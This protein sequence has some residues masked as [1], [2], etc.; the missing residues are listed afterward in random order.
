M[1][2]NI[3]NAW[4]VIY[5]DEELAVA[6]LNVVV[7]ECRHRFTHANPRIIG[8]T[9]LSVWETEAEAKEDCECLRPFANRISR[10]DSQN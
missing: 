4:V 7:N 8:M 5:D 2:N 9:I 10:L 6:R 3:N 1:E